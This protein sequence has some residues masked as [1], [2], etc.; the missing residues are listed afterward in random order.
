[1]LKIREVNREDLKPLC[2]LYTRFRDEA[3]PEFDEKIETIWSSI[4]ADKNH[5]IIVG[6]EAGQIVSSVSVIIIPNLNHDQRPYAL[7]ENVITLPEYRGKGYASA[8][9]DCAKSIAQSENC[10]KIMLMTGSKLPET[11]NFY[12]KAGYNKT[13]KTA[14]IQWLD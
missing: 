8:L 7:V 4:L 14:F 12:E 1:M 10:Y 9:L 5:H 6:E 3:M 11:L 13:D 2:K